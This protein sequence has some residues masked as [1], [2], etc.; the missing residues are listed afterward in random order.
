MSTFLLHARYRIAVTLL[1][2]LLVVQAGAAAPAAPALTI[3]PER[4]TLRLGEACQFRAVVRG[5]PDTPI[6]WSLK[7]DGACGTVSADGYYRAPTR[8]TTPA[9]IR[10][11]AEAANEAGDAKQRARATITLAAVSV[12]VTPTKANLMMGQGLTLRARV[13]QATDER[14]T[15]SVDGGEENGFVTE[16]GHYAAPP[17]FLT[18]GRVTVRATS[19]ADPSKSATATIVIEGVEIKAKRKQVALKLGQSVRLGASVKGTSNPAVEWRVLGT[20]AGEVSAGGV[21]TAPPQM[22]T[23]AVVTVEARSVAD[24]TKAAQTRISIAAVDL[25]VS[26]G[27]GREGVTRSSAPR[28]VMRRVTRIFL[29]LDPIDLLVPGPWFRG[30]SGKLYVPVGGMQMFRADVRNAINDRVLWSVDGDPSLGTINEDGV[31]IAPRTMN[32]PAVIQI[33][34]TSAADPSKVQLVTLHVPPILVDAR[35]DAVTVPLGT[36]QPLSARVENSENDALTWSVEGGERFGTVTAAGLY[37]PPATLTTPAVVN[38]RAT[39]AADPTKSVVIQVRI[40]EVSISLENDNPEVRAGQSVP[41]R[42][43]VRGC[44]NGNVIWK[45]VPDAGQIGP[46]GVYEA[47]S[48][49]AEQVVQVIATCASDPTKSA[50]ATVRIRRE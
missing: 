2:W 38:V 49:A 50:R 22:R 47:P 42:A 33:R 3:R 46:D 12:A 40:P 43:T 27:K 8:C 44:Q 25:K 32:T 1:W 19:V 21:Y 20:D 41:L 34:A 11:I 30:R 15:W 31:F 9:T 16:G 35:K 17:R 6:A 10:L 37:V 5:K 4:I 23:P 36:M 7:G 18:P 48:D 14:V 45:V 28:R 13:N 29:P 39:S 26:Y 24:P